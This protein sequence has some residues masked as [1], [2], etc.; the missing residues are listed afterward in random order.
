MKQEFI[1]LQ[2]KYGIIKINGNQSIEKVH[3]ELK[4]KIDKFLK[5]PFTSSNNN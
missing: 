4:Q 3:N 5:I 2:K 1:R